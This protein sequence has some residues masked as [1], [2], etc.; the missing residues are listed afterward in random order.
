[1]PAEHD[2]PLRA[3]YFVDPICSWSW[4][5][6]PHLRKFLTEFGSHLHLRHRMGGLMGRRD[7][8]FHDPQYGLGGDD[9][10]AYAVHQTEVCEETGM[11]FD[12]RVWAE[13]PPTSSHPACIAV[14]AAQ[15]Q[16]DALGTA[17]LRRVQ[18]AFFTAR[19]AVD[20]RATLEKLARHVPGLDGARFAADLDGPAAAAFEEDFELARRPVPEARDTKETEGRMRYAFPTL[21]LAN[22]E[23]DRRVLDGGHPYGA[24]REAAQALA[25][26]VAPAPAPDV[27]TFLATWGSAATR[28]AAMVCEVPEAEAEMAL[29]GL[30]R[31]GQAMARPAGTRELWVW[32]AAGVPA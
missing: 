27:L 4:G 8:G 16:G 13:H 22:A 20:D 25:P 5:N 26:E 9:P 3:Q 24:Y 1:M 32:L 7:A 29:E 21:I 30:V 17:Y 31:D 28:E 19:G 15:L 14:K 12:A 2:A 11:P 23:G 18:E 10:A 6:E